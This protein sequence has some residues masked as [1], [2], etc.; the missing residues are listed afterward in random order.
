MKLKDA[1]KY[2][3]KA[4]CYELSLD[5]CKPGSEGVNGFEERITILHRVWNT[6]SGDEHIIHILWGVLDDTHHVTI[7]IYKEPDFKELPGLDSEEEGWTLPSWALS[8][9]IE[10][11]EELDKLI[12]IFNAD[13][14]QIIRG[15][16]TKEKSDA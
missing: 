12:E 6:G 11:K 9:L 10:G 15:L 7:P 2:A 3:I 8:G 14:K 16:R 5:I 4:S 13:R 1:L